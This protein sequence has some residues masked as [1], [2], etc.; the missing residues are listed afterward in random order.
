[1]VFNPPD[2][3]PKEIF[4]GTHTHVVIEAI[5]LLYYIL[6]VYGVFFITYNTFVDSSKCGPRDFDPSPSLKIVPVRL[7][8]ISYTS[9]FTTNS[10]TTK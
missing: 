2:F 9:F 1:M 4:S 5:S 6:K 7:P 8:C 10:S 3:F